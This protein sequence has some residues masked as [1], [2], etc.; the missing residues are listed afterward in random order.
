MFSVSPKYFLGNIWCLVKE[1]TFQHFGQQ[2][3]IIFIPPFKEQK[4]PT[5]NKDWLSPYGL[6]SKSF[7]AYY[8]THKGLGEYLYYI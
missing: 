3:I 1:Q 8:Q 7:L 5:S 2:P 4:K 6:S